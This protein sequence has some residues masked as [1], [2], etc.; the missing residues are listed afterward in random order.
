MRTIMTGLLLCAMA[1]LATATLAA[2]AAKNGEVV[3]TL[4]KTCDCVRH[5]PSGFPYIEQRIATCKTYKNSQGHVTAF[6]CPNCYALCSDKP[7]S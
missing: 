2:D 3:E 5:H 7:A 4:R 1:G 6:D